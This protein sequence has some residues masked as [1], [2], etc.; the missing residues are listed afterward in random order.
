MTALRGLGEIEKSLTNFKTGE[1][2]F[3]NNDGAYRINGCLD[4]LNYT[5]LSN[6]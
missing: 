2:G 6:N 3:H 4:V 5:D 1:W